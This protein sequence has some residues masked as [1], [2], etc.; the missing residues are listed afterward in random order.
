MRC[1][2]PARTTV[3]VRDRLSPGNRT[4]DLVE[5]LTR[6]LDRLLELALR[7]GSVRAW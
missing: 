7:G 4:E 1:R 6:L 2:L 3:D 5:R